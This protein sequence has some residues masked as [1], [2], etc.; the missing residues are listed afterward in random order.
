M[1][2]HIELLPECK[3]MYLR[4]E[5]KI[6][7]LIERADKIN[8][9]YEKHMDEGNYYRN[10]VERHDEKMKVLTWLF[11]ILTVP[12]IL[13]CIKAVFANGH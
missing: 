13:L 7:N 2:E 10:K 4:V 5:D 11:G 1:P 3:Q 8:G 12:V 9:R 6:D